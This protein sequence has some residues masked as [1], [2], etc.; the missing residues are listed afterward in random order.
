MIYKWVMQ[1]YFSFNFKTTLIEF[2]KF[3]GFS[4]SF[5]ITIL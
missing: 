4:D 3:Y 1:L 2:N 5:N